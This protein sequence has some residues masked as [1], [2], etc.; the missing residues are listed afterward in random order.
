MI[1]VLSHEF[2]IRLGYFVIDY[3][4]LAG[5]SALE[6]LMKSTKE[7]PP[8]LVE[9]RKDES[10]ARAV[11]RIAISPS[12]QAAAAIKNYG[13]SLGDLE[14]TALVEELRYQVGQTIDGNL[15]RA[16]AMLTTQ[17]HTLD[18]IFGNLA[19]RAIHAEYLSNF[20]TYL[21]LGLR[22][23][24]QCRATW[25]TLAVIKNPMGRAYVGQANFAQNQQI[26]NEAKPSRTREKEIPPN[27]LLEKREHEPDK[28]L[29][30]GTPEETIRVDQVLETVGEID[31]TTD[32]SWKG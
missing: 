13:K 16:E 12:L 9:Q 24:S 11:A 14:L 32:A 25:E 30:R 1:H 31:R 26:N 10:E 7:A 21:K 4:L 27:E 29:D 5:C 6:L 18:A 19:Q 23:Q 22:A 20:D 2:V 3:G 17:A 8:F 28:W 15:D